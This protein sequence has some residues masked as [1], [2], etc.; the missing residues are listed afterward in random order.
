MQGRNDRLDAI[1]VMVLGIWAG[2]L[3][4]TAASAAIIFPQTK[5]L[6]PTLADNIL[7]QVEHWKYLAGKVQNRIFIVSDWI[8][9]FSAI[10]TLALFA[11]IP[12]RSRAALTP[13]LLWRIRVALTS[14]T[15]ALLAAYALWLAPRMR[16]KLA[17]FW[18]TL[19]ARDLDR[20]RIAQAAFESS[21]RVATPMLGA[22]LLCVVATAIATAFSINRAAKPITTTN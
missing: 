13:K 21:H 1:S 3:I 12:A 9:I 6:A 8:Q 15:L 5:E 22:L 11:I 7:P 17:A 20:A 16:A 19:D 4:M 14:I 10:I 2:S 18:T